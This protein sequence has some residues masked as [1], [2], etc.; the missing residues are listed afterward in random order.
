[1]G[2]AALRE[3]LRHVLVVAYYFP[4]LGLSGVQRVT[5]FV[6]YLPEHGWQPT[7]LTVR[8]G[9]YFAFDRSL[10]Q[11]VAT[12][13][14]EVIRTASLDPTRIF[15]SGRVVELPAERVRG[16]LSALSQFVF[17]PDN[18]IGWF[19]AA[20]RAGYKQLRG[21]RYDAIFAS[22]PPYTAHLVG[23]WLGRHARLP[24]VLDFRDDW[25]DNPRHVY[26]TRVH[27][28]LQQ[29]L[30]RYAAGSA[31]RLVAIN[32]HIAS[33]LVERNADILDAERVQVVPQGYD[34]ADF[35]ETAD[36]ASSDVFTLLYAGVFYDAQKPDTVLR[37]MARLRE[38]APEAARRIRLSFVGTFPQASFV[39]ASD[40]GIRDAVQWHGYLPHDEAV[41]HM[42]AASALWVIVGRRP[43]AEGISTG[44]LFEYFGSQ[45][46]ILGLV[47]SGEARRFLEQ[48]GAGIAV[49][50]EDEVATADAIMTMFSNW[51]AGN[52]VRPH[53]DFVRRFDRRRLAGELAG[54]LD[55]VIQVP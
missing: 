46:P 18:K 54:L 38:R 20:V 24:V 32:H 15:G 28:F 26:P 23:A 14:V 35:A 45:K 5:K 33:R 27:R 42:R 21:G 34:P 19:P 25:V 37:A 4:P 43:G 39:L 22:A 9:G 3:D 1:M 29:K 30:E 6:K 44:K 52:P 12:S 49:D 17:L 31:A 8:P 53:H 36:G 7:V 40:L 16:T 47:P 11:E 41:V 10:E 51:E 2:S 48:Y 55:Q 13:N 50:P